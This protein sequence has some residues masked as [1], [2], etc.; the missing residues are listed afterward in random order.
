MRTL[1]I[2]LSILLTG[3]TTSAYSQ[4]HACR[5]RII[6]TSDGSPVIGATTVLLDADST[7]IK[8]GA[9]GEN[10][11]FVL[12]NLPHGHYL[13]KVSFIGYRETIM[14]ID[15]GTEGIEVPL[16]PSATA[17]DQVT[18]I[19]RSVISKSDRKV[20]LPSGEQTRTSTDGTDLLR[21]MQLP[22]IMVDPM[23]GEVT[24]SAGREVQ[25][26]VNGVEVTH[27][28]I[29]ALSPEDIL[30]VEYH[31]NPGVRYGDAGAVIDYITRKRNSGG[32]VNGSFMEALSSV[33]TSR[34]DIL[35]AAFN[36]GKSQFS[37]NAA[38]QHRNQRWTREY[39][40]T[41]R[42]P[43]YS[44]HRLEESEETP[45]DKKI[46][47]SS[48]Q[49]TLSEPGN[50][51][52]NTQFRF[53][54]QDFPSGLEDRRGKIRAEGSDSPVSIY[55][56]T[57]EK[58]K[59]PALDIYF[60]KSLAND[61]VILLNAVGTYST[62]DNV[63]Q[64]RETEQETVLTDIRAQ[65]ESDKYSLIG[66]GIYENRIGSGTLTAGVRHSQS[67]TEN[68][69]TSNSTA[70]VSLRQA[71]THLYTEYQGRAGRLDYMA[72]LRGARIYYSQR[73][74]DRE[75][76]AWEPSGRVAYELTKDLNIRYRADLKTHTPQIGYLNDI[77]QQIDRYQVRRGNPDLKPF[78]SLEQTITLGYTRPQWAVEWNV[79]YIHQFD[80]VMESVL[81][82]DGWFVRTYENQRSFRNFSSELSLRVKPWKDHLSIS[83]TPVIN[84]FISKG[85][86]YLHTYTMYELR[87]AIDFSYDW[88]I[89][90]ANMITP[91]RSVYGEQVFDS[92]Q[93]Y[94][95][96]VGYKRPLWTFLIGA[97]NPFTKNYHIHSEN[98]STLN[99][100]RSD[101]HT[102]HMS[103]TML[104]KLNIKLSYGKEVRAARK[105]LHNADT[106]GG[107]ISGSKN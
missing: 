56:N 106:G 79:G 39:D 17:I 34:D 28:G 26:R 77:Q 25:L 8:G 19:A 74:L 58:T 91:P 9:S 85:N 90:N 107:F 5:G 45:F 37:F 63:R 21:K 61:Q 105:L 11:L 59:I 6:D 32:T 38:L 41:F 80:P 65:V 104:V 100:V 33:K 4:S 53:T 18:I 54:F 1:S 23:T 70:H 97:M 96:M 99:P 42:F 47:R 95:I 44:L 68:T 43:D 62:T 66:E 46:F 15:T 29:A 88:F 27:Y 83:V 67:Y 92:Q 82:E 20:I 52:F 81:Y 89:A 51:L 102:L 13:L 30:R 98:W 49:Y 35:S 71:E 73:G 94:T 57:A 60:Q 64:Y 31:D 2:I 12:N 87:G 93:S 78:R 14:E 10:G 101:I 50:Y 24:M 48:L 86:T 40:E 76:Y 103:R 72:G 3:L 84:R 16:E 7:Y 55:G 69:Y 75:K 36:R 22:R